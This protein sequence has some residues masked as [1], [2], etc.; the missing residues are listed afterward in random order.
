MCP[1][2]RTLLRTGLAGRMT[3]AKLSRLRSSL[4]MVHNAGYAG[5]VPR[6][7][8]AP[9]DRCAP[10]QR[11]FP[12]L[13]AQVRPGAPYCTWST[14]PAPPQRV[15]TLVVSGVPGSTARQP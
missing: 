10:A 1:L 4:F 15:V 7:D 2:A 9:W 5:V 12:L 14:V 11:R 13:P 8:R 3:G 6:E